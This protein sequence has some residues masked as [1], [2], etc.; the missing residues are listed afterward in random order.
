MGISVTNSK[1]QS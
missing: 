1:P